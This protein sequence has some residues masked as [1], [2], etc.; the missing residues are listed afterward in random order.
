MEEKNG[1]TKVFKNSIAQVLDFLIIHEGWDYNKKEI[2]EHSKVAYKTVYD[3]W[4]IF[5]K[6]KII[7]QTRV[8]G[9][10]KM[11]SINK[12]N[13]IV[14]QLKKLQTNIMLQ[15]LEEQEEKN[16]KTAHSIALA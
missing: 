9:R 16:K 7:K 15:A 2:A 4:P 1:L 6:H 8:I 5:E 14:K 11:Y 13:K 3:I 12:E 10:A